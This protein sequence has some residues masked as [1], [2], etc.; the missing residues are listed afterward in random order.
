MKK[1]LLL[2]IIISQIACESKQQSREANTK[3]TQEIALGDNTSHHI[4]EITRVFAAHG[5]FDTW[6]ELKTLSY[7]MGGSTTLVELQNRH[8]RTES[9]GQTVGFDGEKVWVYPASEDA[10][11]QKMRYNLMFYFYAFPFVAGDP[12]VNYQVLSPITLQGK[13]YNAVKISYDAGVGNAPNDTY[14]ICSDTE[15][16]QMEWLLY[17]ATFG[18][19]P[20]DNY[21]LIK[22]ADWQ[23]FGGVKLPTQLQWYLYEDGKVGGP[24]GEAVTFENI[25]VSTEY[26]AMEKFTMPE[27][28]AVAGMTE[29]E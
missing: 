20:K 13:D 9:E 21:S 17:T 16:D 25:R 7:E 1:V 3:T 26:P 14:I 18:G 28:A 22:Y 5:G 29:G 10:D 6:S 4:P 12:G 11:Q 19:A 2:I 27:G 8:I 15:T 24:R 23:E